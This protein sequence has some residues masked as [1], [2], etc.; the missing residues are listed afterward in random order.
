MSKYADILLPLAQ[1]TYTFAVDED[2]GICEGM[3][4][5]VP[6]GYQRDKH[7]TGIVWRLHDTPP[8]AKRVKRVER[9]LYGGRCLVSSE[10]R[11]LWEW[12]ADYYL[13]SLGEV[14]RIALPSLLKPVAEDHEGLCDA[15]Y[16]PPTERYLSAAISEA[17]SQ[18]ELLDKLE[19]RAP[20]QYGA[21]MQI[22][23][24]QQ[25]LQMASIP[26]R[27]LA[28]DIAPLNAL[29]KKGLITWSQREREQSEER[30]LLEKRGAGAFQLPLLTPHQQQALDALER[31]FENHSTALLHGITGSGKTEIY[32]HLI[33]RTLASG[34]D[35]LMLVPEIALTTQLIERL[36]AIF[37][38]RVT[39]Y[40][41]KLTAER[42]TQT[43]LRL[44]HSSGGEFVVGARSALFLPLNHLRLIIVDEEHDS[45]YK[46]SDPAPR[47]NARDCAVAMGHLMGCHTLLGSATPSL[48]SWTN[49]QSGKYGLATLNERY[50]G[51]LLPEIICSDTMRA[52]RRGERKSHFN[53]E[54]RERISAALERGE[55]I[56]L[57]QN[58]RG[59]S[60]FVRCEACG[61]TP[62]CPHC[63]VTLTYHKGRERLV[64]H[65]CGH[66]IPAPSSCPKCQNETLT[67]AGF[68][69]EK[70]TEEISTLW[71]AAKTLRMDRDTVNSESAFR[72]TV[73]A[74]ERG[75]ADILVGTQMITKGFDFGRVSLVGILNADNLLFSPDFRS[76]ERAYQLLSQV[77][78]R[79]GRRERRGE[80][81]IQTSDPTHPVIRRVAAS[82]FE[83]MAREELSEREAFQYP[84]YGRLT[85]FT[86]RHSDRELLFRAATALGET[87][88]GRFGRR[89]LG[90][91][92]PAVDKI[93]DEYIVELLLKIERSA[94][95]LRARALVKEEIAKFARGEFKSVTILTDVD[96]Q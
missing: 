95:S 72:R 87:L 62:R 10:R 31:A 1:P 52:V 28:C 16:T 64:C 71:P 86:L 60:P 12:I 15:E 33:A 41:S 48:E 69:T 32:I 92:T 4:V 88:R 81:V 6:F 70:L 83:A 47:Y 8:A 57:F 76:S 55:Q 17:E 51:T 67:P 26:R 61:W 50:G 78:G 5:A 54:L 40:H 14:M 59:F 22:L 91:V 42:R 93:R 77:A 35:V 24:L 38:S 30:L 90:P 94:S 20:A 44:S 65:Y 36:E 79:A 46:Q 96:P 84:P 66:Q 53:L 34:G 73:K 43:Y 80:V 9:M 75:E 2:M 82:D 85:R 68:G 7:Y 74:F 29:N 56:I 19:R 89:L 37:S 13:C 58:R 25:E 11:K 23:A 49:A 3:A 63:N 39:P 45:S 18:Q 21:L 27:L